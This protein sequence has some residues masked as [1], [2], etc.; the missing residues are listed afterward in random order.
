MGVLM[1]RVQFITLLLV[2]LLAAPI[3]GIALWSISHTATEVLDSCVHW[4]SA[5]GE[6]ISIGPHDPCR[7]ITGHAESKPRA[8]IK[9][10][11]VPGGMLVATILALVGV[12]LSRRRLLITAGI[13]MLAETLLVFSIAPLTFV[14]GLSFIVLARRLGPNLQAGPG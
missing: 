10:A 2:C 13:G 12:V 9:A 11:T 6:A 3:A 8:L 5:P 4:D 7:A 1:P 14:V